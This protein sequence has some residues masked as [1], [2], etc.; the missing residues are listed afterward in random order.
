MNLFRIAS[1]NV[2]SLEQRGQDLRESNA[3]N[4]DALDRID[5]FVQ[6]VQADGRIGV[7]MRPWIL[8]R[9]LSRG[10]YTNIY[11]WAAEMA[12]LSGSDAEAFVGKKL[13]SYKDKRQA[14]DSA[15]ED[16][17]RFG[18]GALTIGGAGAEHYGEFCFVIR[19][20]FA[21]DVKSS[22]YLRGDSLNDYMTADGTLLDSKM[23]QDLAPP[24]HRHCLALLK[25]AP[26]LGA[27]SDWA[28]L[29]CSSSGYIEAI[30]LPD[31]KPEDG[32]E[33]RV[34]A[35]RYRELWDLTFESF[36]RKLAAGESALQAHFVE[37]LTELRDRS[38]PCVEVP[39]C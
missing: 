12:A 36:G 33:V 29:L 30:F 38:L 16:S 6:R 34:R 14:F 32:E 2:N 22:A 25:H 9:F 28:A 19:D 17:E 23:R 18:Y 10:V 39:Q 26:D 24:S 15:F 20:A 37:V 7:N 27:A 5:R 11:G 21:A 13:G 8:A 35:S 1:D 31:L 3:G 4:P